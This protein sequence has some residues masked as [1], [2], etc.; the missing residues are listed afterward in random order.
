MN[1]NVLFLGD[2]VKACE[3]IA[4]YI[5]EGEAVFMADERT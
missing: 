4:G 2:I 1:R 5:N 3:E